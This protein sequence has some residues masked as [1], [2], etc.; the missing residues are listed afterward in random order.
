MQDAQLSAFQVVFDNA[1]AECF[2]LLWGRCMDTASLCTYDGFWDPSFLTYQDAKDLSNRLGHMRTMDAMNVCRPYGIEESA[3]KTAWSTHNI[4]VAVLVSR[5]A[6]NAGLTKEGVPIDE[7]TGA[8]EAP[9][10]PGR[11]YAL[12]LSLYEDHTVAK[13]I[14]AVAD[15][16]DGMNLVRGDWSE[17]GFMAAEDVDFFIPKEWMTETGLPKV[18]LFQFTYMSENENFISEQTRL[19]YAVSMLGMR[20]PPSHA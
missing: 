8:G 10:E 11:R 2:V 15:A 18:G 17:R 6:E 12:D 19:D 4:T 14:M 7:K 16:E 1:R 9:V 20:R 5:R 13:Y 3:F